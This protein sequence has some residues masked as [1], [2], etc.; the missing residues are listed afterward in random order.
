MK[1]VATAMLVVAAVIFLIARSMEEATPWLGYVRATAEA[2]MVGAL[3]DWFA[4]TAL[5]RHP[6]GL[7]IPHTAI[8]QTR[9][10]QIGESLGG[11]VR[12][13]FLTS[14]VVAERLESAD[15][16]ARIGDW[17]AE[18][19][20]A[21]TVS[22][23]SAAVVGGITEVLQDDIVQGGVESVLLNRARTIPVAPLMGRVVEAAFEGDHHQVLLDAVLNGLGNF[24]EENR[25]AFRTR[26]NSESPWWVPEPV[27][28]VV[29]EKIYEVVQNFLGELATNRNHDM[30]LDIDQRTRRLA[31]DLKT[32]DEMNERG[33]DIKEQ[34]LSHPEVRAWSSSLWTRM[35]AALIE[36]TEDPESDL[37]V[38][39]DEALVE[40]GRSLQRDPEL[41]AKVDRWII[42]A[43]G[44]VA[45]QFRGEVADLIAT[46]V[47]GWDNEETAERLELQVGRD[48][49][50]IR[51]NG[52]LVGG[53]AGLAIYSVSQ[54]LFG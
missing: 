40:A 16:A 51:I 44:Y 33:E 29:F 26:L 4:V 10:D 23:Q 38:H 22:S 5:F 6:L 3:A 13:N 15:L 1:A 27:D 47:Q 31:E 50:F 20:N 48:L 12:D 52:T 35:K 18:P 39:L 17:L 8:I 46:T 11:F 49:Q 34:I 25:P 21:R 24:M 41:R 30:R 54:W 45:E 14:A 37:R 36:A 19:D 2:A 28:D 42:E 32:S 43:T 7:P 53:F 9:K